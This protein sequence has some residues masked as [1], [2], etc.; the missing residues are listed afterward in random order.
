MLTAGHCIADASERYGEK[1]KLE[2]VLGAFHWDRLEEGTVVRK[3]N[4]LNQLSKLNF[5]LYFISDE[6]NITL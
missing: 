5:I 3:V 1:G 2:L 6:M 4:K